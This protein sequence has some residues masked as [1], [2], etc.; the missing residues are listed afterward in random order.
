MV[1]MDLLSTSNVADA[2]LGTTGVAE[3]LPTGSWQAAAAQ[4]DALPG[5]RPLD[6]P[7]G[8]G[9]ARGIALGVA[10]GALVWLGIIA[11]V[12]SVLARSSN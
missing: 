7:D 4:S 1:A 6:G 10:L 3:E 12:I 9:D 11:A 2:R 5:T 8:L